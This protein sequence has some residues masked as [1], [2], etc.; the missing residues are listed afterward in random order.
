MPFTLSDNAKTQLLGMF[1]KREGKQPH[2]RVGVKG[3]GCSGYSYLFDFDEE[4]S[5]DDDKVFDF[6]KFKI[7]IDKKSYF[8][9]S[10]TELD[11]VE[12]VMGSR[13]TFKN[14]E[15]TSTCGCGESVAF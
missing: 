14:P 15:V 3:G 6:E 7:V 9:L 11:Y 2:L 10:N 12:E 8:F 1:A 5:T 4:P 13:F